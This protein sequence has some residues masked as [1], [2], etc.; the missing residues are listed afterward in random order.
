MSTGSLLVS[1]K[2]YRFNIVD[3]VRVGGDRVRSQPA[4]GGGG[5]ESVHQVQR[6][7][8]PSAPDRG[9]DSG[10]QTRLPPERT[11]SQATQGG[12]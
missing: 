7:C 10:G 8:Q 9:V 5:R 4:R 12:C 11:S 6:E 2:R 1:L 3:C